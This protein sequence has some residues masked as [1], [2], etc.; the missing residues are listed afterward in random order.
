MRHDEY[1]VWV[2]IWA[3]I[4]S[5]LGLNVGR[6][7]GL[8]CLGFLLGLFLGPIGILIIHV[9]ANSPT[10]PFAESGYYCDEC[11]MPVHP[12]ARKCPYCRTKFA[13]TAHK[14][15]RDSSG[16]DLKTG[17]INLLAIGA[18]LLVVCT[19][20]GFALILLWWIA[21]WRQ[22]TLWIVLAALGILA[23]AILPPLVA[24]AWSGSTSV[25]ART[26]IIMCGI[27]TGAVFLLLTGRW[28]AS[29]TT[30]GWV[31]FVSILLAALVIALGTVWVM[32]N[33]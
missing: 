33:R 16:D 12:H 21:T 15:P 5:M 25:A 11:R 18:V 27:A 20:F 10:A 8:G 7:R 23:Y 19:A 2:L 1:L 13:E 29:W 24:W 9:L 22:E 28:M 4:W 31:W 32:R 26:S 3:F 6:L 30:E 17:C 14:K